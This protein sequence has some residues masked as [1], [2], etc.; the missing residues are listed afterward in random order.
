MYYRNLLH[1]KKTFQNFAEKKD[2][3]HK[4]TRH[5]SEEKK[6]KNRK[7]NKIWLNNFHEKLNYLTI[8][9]LDSVSYSFDVVI[10]VETIWR[11]RFIQ[12]D[13]IRWEQ[14]EN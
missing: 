4:N 14:F 3:L 5:L 6:R 2:I 10:S 12:C 8:Y 13:A 7:S 9:Y 11:I 1:I